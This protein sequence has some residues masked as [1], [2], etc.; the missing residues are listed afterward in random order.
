MASLEDVEDANQPATA[1]SRPERCG[2]YLMDPIKDNIPRKRNA[3]PQHS[4]L[5]HSRTPGSIAPGDPL[6]AGES[7]TEGQHTSW[8][9][10]SCTGLRSADA[11]SCR[12]SS[13]SRGPS[14]TAAA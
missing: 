9:L 1:N 5:R 14:H 3:R 8:S 4:P 6:S 13:Y 11:P 10:S 12:L 2:V 7:R